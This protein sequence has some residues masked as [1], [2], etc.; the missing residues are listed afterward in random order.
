MTVKDVYY[1][2]ECNRRNLPENYHILFLLYMLVMYAD[3]CFV[4][5]NKKGEI[6]GY[7]IG[8]LKD[9]LEKD[10]TTKT[11]DTSGYILSL[12]VDKSYRG[13]G[14]GKILFS[15][16]LYSLINRLKKQARIFKVYLN[17]RETNTAAITMY[18]RVFHFSKESEEKNY[19]ADG[20]SSFLMSRVFNI[21][22]SE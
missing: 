16:S 13:V 5:E 8:K 7:S 1:V 15:L 14:L 21:N 12:A 17:V 19:Y 18:E 3:S 9:S 10:E 2:K 20:E 11:E 6:I 22:E 4:A